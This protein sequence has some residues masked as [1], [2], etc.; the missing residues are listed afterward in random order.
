MT[1]DP[2]GRWIEYPIGGTDQSV[3]LNGGGPGREELPLPPM[4]PVDWI[5][6]PLPLA[7]SRHRPARQVES[8]SYSEPIRPRRLPPT[9]ITRR[10]N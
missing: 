8:A 4:I 3:P 9:E 5:E 7:D 1:L 2:D 10:R 6:A